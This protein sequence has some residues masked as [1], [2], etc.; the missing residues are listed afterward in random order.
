MSQTQRLKEIIKEQSAKIHKLEN[1]SIQVEH[2]CV[3]YINLLK[4]YKM[5]KGLKDVLILQFQSI[6]LPLQRANK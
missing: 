2:D 4:D 5:D 3:L 1:A 6:K